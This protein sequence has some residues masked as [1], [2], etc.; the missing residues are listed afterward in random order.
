MAGVE[1]VGLQQLVCFTDSYHLGLSRI[2]F[3]R[4]SQRI[5]HSLSQLRHRPLRQ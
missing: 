3:T 2:R 4:L 5:F 1:R